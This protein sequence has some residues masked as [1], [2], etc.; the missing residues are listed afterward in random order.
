MSVRIRLALIFALGAALVIGVGGLVFTRELSAGLTGS[1]VAGLRSRADTVAQNLG[2]SAGPNV[3]DPGG[4]QPGPTA[5]LASQSDLLTQVIGPNGAVLDAFGPGTAKPVLSRGELASARRAELILQRAVTRGDAPMLLLAMPAGDASGT[6]VIT[7]ISLTTV[8][9]AR[10]RVEAALLIGG[11]LAVAL[12]GLG[13]WLLAGA[14]LAPVERMRRQAAKISGQD[15]DTVLSVPGTGDELAALART[16]NDMLGRLHR[17]LS[18]QR[19]FLAVAGHELRTPLAVLKGEVELALSP[20]RSRADLLAALREAA[21]ETDRLIKLAEDL[22]TLAAADEGT[23]LVRPRRCDIAAVIA[24]AVAAWAD[25]AR[26]KGV[27]L[28]L[29]SPAHLAAM[30]DSD[31]LRQVIDNLFDNALRFAPS[32]SAIEVTLRPEGGAAVLEVADKGPGFPPGFL[33]VAFER[34]S[35]PEDHR[36]EHQGSG[37]GLAIVKTLVE[38]HGGQVMAANRPGGGALIR[39]VLPAAASVS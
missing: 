6:V 37:L 2:G 35:R 33:P 36:D 25:P 19:G 38:A 17:A 9:Q 32:R 21:G 12:A 27:E 4:G 7:G 31:R 23:P 5:G 1:L 10:S 8:D 29:A 28:R 14:A 20:G 18:R 15:A 22:L 34:F 24:A 26:K 3:Q 13:A 30:G 11:P 16:L 39:V